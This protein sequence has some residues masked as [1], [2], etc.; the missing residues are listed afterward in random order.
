[1]LWTQAAYEE[2]MRGQEEL[3]EQGLKSVK[4]KFNK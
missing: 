4:M 3:V 1:V 2:K